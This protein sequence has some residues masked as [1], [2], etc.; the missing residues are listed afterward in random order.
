MSQFKKLP[1][2]AWPAGL[3]EIPEP[4]T[5]LSLEGQLPPAEFKYLTIIGSRKYSRYGEDVCRKIVEEIA[6]LNIVVVSGLALGIDTIAHKAALDNK[7]LTVAFPGSGLDREVLHPHSNRKLADEIVATGGAL[8]SEFDPKYPAGLHTFPR[9]NRLMAGIAQATLVIEAGDKSGTL[10]TARLAT[11]YNRDVLAVPG[12]I[13]SAGSL[14]TNRLIRQGATPITSGDDVAEALGFERTDSHQLKLNLAD[15]GPNERRVVEII[16]I[17]PVSRDELIQQL[18]LPVSE[19]N[20]L[21]AVMEIKGLI[22]E[23]LG[24]IRLNT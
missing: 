20:S 18:N 13:F 9:R 23:T 7:M 16:Q 6:H 15:L 19:V 24:E 5:Q 21:L 22:K 1:A 2:D 17:E 3:R 12:P 8:L 14:G 10:I 4:P 11:D